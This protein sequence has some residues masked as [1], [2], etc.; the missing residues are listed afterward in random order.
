MTTCTVC[1]TEFN[2][3]KDAAYCSAKCRQK[4]HRQR[5]AKPKAQS[6]TAK[7]IENLRCKALATITGLTDKDFRADERI[8][9]AEAFLKG[10]E[11]YRRHLADVS[12]QKALDTYYD[13]LDRETKRREE[14]DAMTPEQ[15]RR[16]EKRREA[17][18]VT[19]IDRKMRRN[20]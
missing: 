8:A 3:R 2:G 6:K 16:V 14:W 4:A 13:M 11:A 20:A 17:H 10:P 7:V 18:A 1:N 19:R 9:S 12:I 5:H 15:Q